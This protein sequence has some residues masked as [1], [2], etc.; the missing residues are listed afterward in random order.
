MVTEESVFRELILEV[1][2]SKG[3]SSTHT[4]EI[5][6]YIESQE[7]SGR[8]RFDREDLSPISASNSQPRWK[9]N[10]RNGYGTLKE[11]GEIAH[12]G[13]ELYSLP[14]ECSDGCFINPAEGW[15][16]SCFKATYHHE[17]DVKLDTTFNDNSYWIRSVGSAGISITKCTDSS[18]EGLPT[19]ESLADG[20]IATIFFQKDYIIQAINNLNNAGGFGYWGTLKGNRRWYSEVIISLNP[21]IVLNGDAVEAIQKKNI[22]YPEF[23]FNPE[24]KDHRKKIQTEDYVREGREEFRESLLDV[25]NNRCIISGCNVVGALDAA[26]IAPYRGIKSNHLQNGIILRKD[27]HA[28]FDRHLITIHPETR[29]VMVD[30]SIIDTEYGDFSGLEIGPPNDSR[31]S[32]SSKALSQ[33]F[34]FFQKS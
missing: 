10:V 34:E 20:S 32:P 15:I 12:V 29:I 1:V 13:H 9:R 22:D 18:L 8:L 6:D 17:N 26:H 4:N 7:K 3:G 25:Y 19:T 23:E 28:L 14:R 33:N 24:M 27:I 21:R 16:E 2:K 5:Y 30:E 11:E 31:L